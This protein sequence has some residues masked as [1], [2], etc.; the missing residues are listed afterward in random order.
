LYKSPTKSP[1]ALYTQTMLSPTNPV[2]KTSS[3]NPTN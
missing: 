1:N 3:P 2:I